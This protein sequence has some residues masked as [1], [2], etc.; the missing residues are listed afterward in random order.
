M[1]IWVF[2]GLSK[3]TFYVKN[4]CE[5]SVYNAVIEI[6]KSVELITGTK[7]PI[8]QV[9]CFDF[10]TNGVIFATFDDLAD[11][12]SV[13]SVEM[14]TLKET[15]G[16]VIKEYK[17]NLYILSHKPAGVF[18]G[19]HDL[20][21]KNADIIW[22]RAKRGEEASFIPSENLVLHN[23]NYLEKPDFISRGWNT[24]GVGEEGI[25]H[26]LGTMICF[27][28]NKINT[29]FEMYLDMFADYGVDVQGLYVPEIQ[30]FRDEETTCPEYFMVEEDGNPRKSREELSFLNYFNDDI[31]RRMADKI[32]LFY[33]KNPDKVGKRLYIGIP[34]DDFFRMVK[35]GRVISQEPFKADDGTI[36]YPNEENYKSTVYYNFINRVVK[37]VCEVYKNA[38]F[39]TL[40]YLYAFPCPKIKVD[41]RVAIGLCPIDINE[42]LIYRKDTS[43][44]VI[45]MFD[46]MQRWCDKTVDVFLYAYWQ[47]VRNGY[48]RPLA[49]NV[50]ENLKDFK[51]MGVRHLIPEGFLDESNAKGV[52][53]LF[54]LNEMYVWQMNKLFWNVNIDLDLLTEK[55]CRL[56]YGKAKDDMI[57]FYRLI[58]KGWDITDGFVTW[59]TGCDVYIKEC[60]INVGLADKIIATLESGLNKELIP[61]QKRRILSIYNILKTKIDKI[62]NIPDEQA[63]FTYCN[64]GIDYI[65]S[66]EQ[67]QVEENADS[68]WNKAN[69]LT[70]FKN[71]ITL[72]D[73]PKEIRFNTRLLYD[74]NY[75]Y[76]GFQVF[77]DSIDSVIG[78][79]E[80][81]LPLI[82]R[83]N[84]KLIQSYAENYVSAN[85]LKYGTYFGYITGIL[86]KQTD[87]SFYFNDGSPRKIDNPKGFREGF[88][89]HTDENPSKRY[90]F[91]VQA[92]AFKDVGLEDNKIEPC[93]S[94]LYYTDRYDFVG[95]KGNGLWCKGSFSK[96]VL[97]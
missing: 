84:G 88:Y 81:G 80:S 44:K 45:H 28:K 93:G 35:D 30:D 29:K 46:N 72:E 14:E 9:D 18:F 42:H 40:A 66:Q 70:V 87:R 56:V 63:K 7:V 15:D 4:N 23:Y 58:Q 24:C 78:V 67:L 32:I 91:H 1:F 38:K 57:E 83:T 41:E 95:W 17:S 51:Q 52:S 61:S 3:T 76:F 90:Y 2:E 36:V 53:E 27:A 79:N 54:D 19:A 96:Y 6:N 12:A 48:P 10:V 16:F 69:K 85:G 71:Y 97:E 47:S 73:Y 11:L 60:I 8:S 49:K 43:S 89:I 21:E 64:K 37:Y 34:D 22:T 31:A 39:L 86:P 33:K 59:A 94:F 50:Q 65:L 25:H 26:D 82:K 77:D 74:E 20:L 68:V 55:Y 13:F 92:I 5:K 75:L 62:I